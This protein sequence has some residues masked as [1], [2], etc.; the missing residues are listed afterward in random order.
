MP[1]IVLIMFKE[2]TISCRR[3]S[4]RTS[5]VACRMSIRDVPYWSDYAGFSGELVLLPV[6]TSGLN[7]LVLL[8][9]V[10]LKVPGAP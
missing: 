6:V 3:W 7:V 4:R 2:N 1:L 8:F 10:G 9:V 5:I